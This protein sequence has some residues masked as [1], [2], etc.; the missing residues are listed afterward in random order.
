[1]NGARRRREEIRLRARRAMIRRFSKMTRNQLW[2]EF[3]DEFEKP[4]TIR[5]RVYLKTDCC[6]DDGFKTSLTVDLPEDKL[7]EKIKQMIQNGFWAPRFLKDPP[8]ATYVAPGQIVQV[9]LL[10]ENNN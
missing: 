10:M 5:A 9:K 1:M 4:A 8:Y 3:K 6:F 2:E 7:T